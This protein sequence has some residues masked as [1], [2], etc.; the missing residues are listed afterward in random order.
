[1]HSTGSH[2]ATSTAKIK[3]LG[4]QEQILKKHTRAHILVQFLLDHFTFVLQTQSSTKHVSDW[5]YQQFKCCLC[6]QRWEHPSPLPLPIF[7]CCH[8]STLNWLEARGTASCQKQSWAHG[9]CWH[10]CSSDHSNHELNREMKINPAKLAQLKKP[11]WKSYKE[12]SACSLHRDTCASLSWRGVCNTAADQ[13]Y[14]PGKET[15]R[16]V[17]LMH[18]NSSSDSDH[19]KSAVKHQEES[20]TQATW[21]TNST[22]LLLRGNQNKHLQQKKA[23]I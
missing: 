4:Q 11:K 21:T 22:I 16:Q 8:R 19:F 23:G 14:L 3:N 1:M 20:L 13:F 7:S 17:R 5:T 10:W 6:S 2:R 18:E 15:G 9:L 12:F